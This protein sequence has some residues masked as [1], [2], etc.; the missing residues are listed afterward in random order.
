MRSCRKIKRN[1]DHPVARARLNDPKPILEYPLR[2]GKRHSQG[3]IPK[4]TR[5]GLG[6]VDA[7]IALMKSRLNF[8]GK[9][10]PTKFPRLGLGTGG[11]K[12]PP[13]RDKRQKDSP[14]GR[15]SGI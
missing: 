12:E 1:I 4:K 13:R 9:G 15:R 11:A 6:G 7:G 2:F 5:Q 14:M 3:K 8:R 10:D